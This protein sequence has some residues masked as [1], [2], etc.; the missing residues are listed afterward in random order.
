MDGVVVRTRHKRLSNTTPRFRS[1]F[2][3]NREADYDVIVRRDNYFTMSESKKLFIVRHCIAGE[4][5]KLFVNKKLRNMFGIGQNFLKQAIRFFFTK[6]FRVF[7]FLL[8]ACD[9]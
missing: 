4:S 8:I 2:S 6:T 5:R 7:K 1:D 9:F 3:L